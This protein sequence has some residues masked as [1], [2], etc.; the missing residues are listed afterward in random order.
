MRLRKEL[1][2]AISQHLPVVALEST[3]IAHGLPQPVNLETACRLEATVRTHGAFPATIAVLDGE[4]R[5]GL[6]DQELEWLAS[7]DGIGKLSIR[8]LPVAIARGLNGATT[9]AATIA[10]AERAGIHV[11]S[12][13]GIGG[14]H[15]GRAFDISADLP[16]LARTSMVVVC[17]G[18]KS[19]LNIE[20]TREW[21][22]TYGVTV[23]GYGSMEFPSFFSPRS[24]CLADIRC[25]S[26]AEIARIR[27]AR[28]RI[29]LEGAILVTVPV[30]GESEI[31]GQALESY[32]SEALV[33]ADQQ[34]ITGSR[35][36]PFILS[37]MNESSEGKTLNANIALLENNARVAAGIAVAI[38]ELED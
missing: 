21:L 22:E 11:L 25:D 33:A 26:V 9:V 20:A 27:E 37:R 38:H 6:T 16:S 8:D 10:I 2:D 13:G 4:V 14:V 28:R 18:P 34:G 35:L 5:V 19:M 30:P 29:D 24:A 12:T 3:V 23:I 31:D 32:L 1:Q 36:T 17:S 7:G 15:R